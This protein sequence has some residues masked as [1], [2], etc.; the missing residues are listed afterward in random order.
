MGYL[1]TAPNLLTFTTE[2]D[3]N[4]MLSTINK[5]NAYIMSEFVRSPKE[6]SY[7]LCKSGD[8]KCF[9]WRWVHQ[10]L[11]KPSLQSWCKQH[12]SEGKGNRE[13]DMQLKKLITSSGGSV[14]VGGSSSFLPL[15]WHA[16][17]RAW[18]S[19]PFRGWPVFSSVCFAASARTTTGGGRV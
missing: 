9:H 13:E 19:T 7:F 18:R 14:T 16:P 6:E 1:L 3:L 12:Q 10:H 4:R 15:A 2:G 5:R 11:K 8:M 17:F